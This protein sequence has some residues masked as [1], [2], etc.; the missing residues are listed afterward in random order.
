MALHS[1]RGIAAL[2]LTHTLAARDTRARALQRDRVWAEAT[3]SPVGFPAQTVSLPSGGSAYSTTPAAPARQNSVLP[4]KTYLSF[5]TINV[6]A[7]KRK[8]GQLNDDMKSSDVRME[9]SVV[10]FS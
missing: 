2:T 9:S 7:V 5:K 10:T 4:V 3:P 6:D 8:I 1:V